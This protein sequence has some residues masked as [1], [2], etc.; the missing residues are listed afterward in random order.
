MNNKFT[1]LLGPSFNKVEP[2]LLPFYH[3][4]I[5]PLGHIWTKL[6]VGGRVKLYPLIV[7]DIDSGACCF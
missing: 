3:V 5:D 6:D 4:S 7:L 2:N 1:P